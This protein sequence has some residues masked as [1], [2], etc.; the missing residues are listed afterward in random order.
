MKLTSLLIA[1]LCFTIMLQAQVSK[2]LEVTAGG[3]KTALTTEELNTVTK[4]TLTGTIDARD[5]KTM[6]DNKIGRA[7]CRGTVFM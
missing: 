6:R 7:S 1:G 4:L 5:F 3:L 2:N